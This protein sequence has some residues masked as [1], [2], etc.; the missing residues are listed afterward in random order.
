MYILTDKLWFPPVESS[1]PDGLL[2]F[3]GD[4][5]VARLT[6]AYQHGI[7]PWFSE[8]EPIIWYSP[9]PR[10]V[11]FL[12][13]LKVSKSMRQVLKNHNYRISFNQ[14]F[15]QVIEACK[16]VPRKGQQ[17]TWITDDMTAAYIEMHNI[18]RAQSVEVWRG[19]TLVGGLYGVHMGRVFC[20]ESMFSLVVG[21]RF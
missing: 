18:G 12:D 6:L 4:L 9:D 20:G 11:L 13:E 7:F 2:A 3:G 16:R 10:M 17:G 8:G 1:L 19:D 14:D 21:S 15:N 5:S